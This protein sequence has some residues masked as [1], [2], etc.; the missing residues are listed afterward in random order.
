MYSET[1]SH[2]ESAGDD[3]EVQQ[4]TSRQIIEQ[5]L[6]EMIAEMNAKRSRD[7]TLLESMYM[8]FPIVLQRCFLCRLQEG[9]GFMVCLCTCCY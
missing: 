6:E 4:L 5:N 2:S 1:L 9:V 3:G 8:V 7:Q